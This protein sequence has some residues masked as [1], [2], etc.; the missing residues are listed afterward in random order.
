MQLTFYGEDAEGVAGGDDIE[1]G[2]LI[3][4]L[5]GGQQRRAPLECDSL[6][7]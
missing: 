3:E 6:R 2:A 4:T 7:A 5:E 1:P